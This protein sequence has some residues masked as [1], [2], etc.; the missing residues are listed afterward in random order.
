MRVTPLILALLLALPAHAQKDPRPALAIVDARVVLSPTKTLPVATVI[1]RNGV[2]TAVGVEIPIPEDARRI[3]GKG[4]TV[5]AGFI[6]GLTHS[7]HQFAKL[8]K[9]VAKARVELGWDR[10]TQ[11]PT[12]MDPAL[13]NGIWAGRQV[14]RNLISNS[15]SWSDQRKYGWT[16][17]LVAPKTGFVAGRSALVAYSGALPRHALLGYDNAQH[18]RF[19]YRQRKYPGTVM[20]TM[21]YLRQLFSDAAWH[22]RAWRIYRKAGEKGLRRPPMDPDLMAINT[23]TYFIFHV[24]TENEIHRALDLA[25]EFGLRAGIAGGQFAFK[26]T[27][28]LARSKTP[29]ILSLAWPEK[30]KDPNAKK[31]KKKAKKG[32]EKTPSAK[33]KPETV[34]EKPAPKK[35]RR[36][37]RRRPETDV[38]KRV[39]LDRLA[40][41]NRQV[42]CAIALHKAGIPFI[43]ST[44][45]TGPK[46]AL[47]RIEQLIGWGLPVEAALT[48]L[49]QRPATLYLGG[50]SLG[51][52]EVGRAAHLL[53][54]KGT[55]GK[56]LSVQQA[57]VDGKL[58]DL[59]SSSGVKG[60][61][62]V[63]LSG[64][65][66]ISS[67][68]ES[69]KFKATA[70]LKQT[71]DGSLTGQIVTRFGAAKIIKGKVGGKQFEFTASIKFGKQ[72]YDLEFNG[73]VSEG[74]IDGTITFG[75]D[76][77]TREFSAVRPEKSSDQKK[78]DN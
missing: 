49:T 72:S 54:C 36:G 7:G 8:P 28:R 69:G 63:D 2:I 19:D 61:A 25:Q 10:S 5:Y 35:G 56:K 3:P 11:V 68:T 44:E 59:T 77:K 52:I 24:S 1:I 53:V 58:F 75:W 6:D 16:A 64:K 14:Y 23:S 78:E 20:G 55:L 38:P 12:G 50:A 13:R 45:G 70:E 32:D 60:K 4:R 33:A 62:L 29:V 21:A 57:I 15:S 73:A 46:K 48:A 51:Q 9:K 31:K 71:S 39:M 47:E 76:G 66:T 34:K 40:R 43:F 37:K 65:W 22:A 30:P 27:D 41:W 67:S 74:K 18:I 17:G 42:R 26:L